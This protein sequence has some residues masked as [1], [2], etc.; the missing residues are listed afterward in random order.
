MAVY[1]RGDI[2]A[3]TISATHGGCGTTHSR[4]VE[5]GAPA[6]IWSLACEAGCEDYLRSDPLWS[7]TIP[8]IPETYDETKKRERDEKAGKL[9]RENQLAAALI[10]LGGLAQL[11]E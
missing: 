5:Q 3:V 4:P 11:P 1:A 7:A 8:E 9:D 6:R 2:A 10:E